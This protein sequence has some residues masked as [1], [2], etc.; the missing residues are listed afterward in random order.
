[1]SRLLD[2]IDACDAEVHDLTFDEEDVSCLA[3]GHVEFEDCTFVGCSFAETH[4]DRISFERC[5]FEGCDFSNAQLPVSF[6]RDDIIRDSRL[7]G[8]NLMRGHWVRSSLE[9]C[10]CSFVNFAESK[11]EQLSLRHCDLREA[12]L[13]QMRVKRLRLE[14]CDLTRAEVFRTRLSGVDLSTCT[15]EG[16]RVSDTFAE[17]RGAKLGID[18]APEV[19]GLLGIKLV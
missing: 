9:G 14:G 10:A 13:S 2:A 8:C 16:M 5:T 4:A 6:W 1:M 11:V 3:L 7:V 15:I 17:L 12:S 19:M 18:Q